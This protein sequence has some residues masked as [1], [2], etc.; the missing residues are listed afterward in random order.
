MMSVPIYTEPA[1]AETLGNPRATVEEVYSQIP[2]SEFLINKSMDI[3]TDQNPA[4][5]IIAK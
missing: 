1:T 2:E 5:G 4:D 3:A